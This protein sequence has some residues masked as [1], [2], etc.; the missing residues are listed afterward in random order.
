MLGMMFNVLDKNIYFLHI[1]SDFNRKL[2]IFLIYA[3]IHL[4]FI[5][6]NY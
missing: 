6:S 2:S 3:K 5:Y 1:K 4:S